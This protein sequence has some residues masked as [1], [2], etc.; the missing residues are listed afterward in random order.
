MHLIETVR[1]YIHILR[2]PERYHWEYS[3]ARG[4]LGHR[5]IPL[6]AV[7]QFLEQLQA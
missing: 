4:Y 5:S 6:V 2:D 7:F 3:Q 1:A